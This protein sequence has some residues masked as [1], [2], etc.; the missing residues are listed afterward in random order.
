ME[1]TDPARSVLSITVVKA[2]T[3]GRLCGHRRHPRIGAENAVGR[4]WDSRGHF[5]AAAEAMRRLLVESARRKKRLRDGLG[6]RLVDLDAAESLELVPDEDLLA[7]D[8]AL[9]RLTDLDSAK[10]EVVKLRFFAGLT[11]PEIASSLDISLST[12]ER[13]WTFARARLYARLSGTNSE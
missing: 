1:N 6:R 3:G 10:A 5:F 11:M 7:I 4:K 9:T 12:T 2:K 13:H 8:E